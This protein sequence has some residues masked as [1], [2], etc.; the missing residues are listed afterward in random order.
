MPRF[1]FDVT[2]GSRVSP[3]PEGL[4]LRNLQAARKE[5]LATLGSN[6][7]DELPGGDRREI[8][9]S[10]RDESSKPVLI[11]TLSMRIEEPSCQPLE[12]LG[13]ATASAVPTQCRYGPVTRTIEKLGDGKFAASTTS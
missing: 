3:D 12:A 6:A 11:A 4:E 2:V 1:Y 10:I 9:I 13:A 8:I 7:K 5:T